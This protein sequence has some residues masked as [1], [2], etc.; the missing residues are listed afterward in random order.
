MIYLDTSVL[1]S[2]FLPETASARV[3][4]WLEKHSDEI[5]AISDWTRTEFAS[6]LAL[7]VRRE[8]LNH[9]QAAQAQALFIESADASLVQ[10]EISRTDFRLAAQLC[11]HA[12]SG[13]RAGDAL[14]LAVT[15]QHGAQLLTLDQTLHA[16]AQQ[17]GASVLDLA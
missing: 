17:A 11:A 16:A 7:K 13:L 14:H 12:D 15:L 5:L 9:A 1:V 10:L 4:A 6:A 3:H 8:E 2:A